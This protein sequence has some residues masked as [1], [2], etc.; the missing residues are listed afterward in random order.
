MAPGVHYFRIRIYK[1]KI[2]VSIFK[3]KLNVGNLELV[4]HLLFLFEV[5]KSYQFTKIKNIYFLSVSFINVW[6]ILTLT[7]D[8]NLNKK[9]NHLFVNYSNTF[10]RVKILQIKVYLN[11]MQFMNM[12]STM[13][14]MNLKSTMQ[15]M[16]IKSLLEY[17]AIH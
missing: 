10:T 12:K 3:I 16:N 5:Q 17:N 6:K 9:Q 14:F 2:N 11:T 4:S 8:I 1:P 7:E 13:Q 15:F